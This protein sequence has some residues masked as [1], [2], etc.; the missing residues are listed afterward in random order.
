MSPI[1]PG[2]SVVLVHGLWMNGLVFGV[3]RQRLQQQHGFDVDTFTYPTLH[4]HAKQVLGDLVDF[5]SRNARGRKVH[6]VGHSL[7]GALVYRTLHDYAGRFDGNAVLLGSPLKGSRAARSASQW[8]MLRPLLG[9]H[10]LEELAPDRNRSCTCPNAIGAIAGNLRVGMGQFIAHFD[11]ESDGTVA[12][13]ETIIPG[14]SDHLVLPHSHMGM[15]FADDVA[16]QV[17]HFLRHAAFT[18]T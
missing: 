17:A 15:L 1:S 4:G 3:L 10:V 8:P 7:G 9:P 13:S 11:E 16:A 18:R 2:D 14:L 12:V 5:A 6:F